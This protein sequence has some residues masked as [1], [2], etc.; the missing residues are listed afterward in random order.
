M[1]ILWPTLLAEFPSCKS[2]VNDTNRA[3]ESLHIFETEPRRMLHQGPVARWPVR[4]GLQG[5]LTWAPPHLPHVP[6]VSRLPSTL[7]STKPVPTGPCWQKSL[8]T[9]VLDHK[10]KKKLTT[11]SLPP[12]EINKTPKQQMKPCQSIWT[13]AILKEK[14]TIRLEIL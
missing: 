4:K 7:A 12:K 3:N 8:G 10:N 5:K 9:T 14:P 13:F 6:G 11:L 2:G 1:V